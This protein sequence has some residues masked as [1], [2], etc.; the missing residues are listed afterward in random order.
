IGTVT[1]IAGDS[2]RV[3]VDGVEHDVE[4]AVWERY[5][6]AY[7]PGTKNLSREIVAEFTQFPLRL[8]WAV[9][10][11]KSQGKPYDRAVVDLGAGAFAPVRPTSRSAASPR[12]TGSTCRDRCA[13][14]TSVSTRTC[15]A[16]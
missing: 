12:S 9:T 2:V 15:A 4:P 11:H 13:R 5:R 1:R 3:E 14:A 10:I 16:S 8:A 6:Y 7:D